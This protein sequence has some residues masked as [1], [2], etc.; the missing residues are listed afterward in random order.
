MTM[1]IKLSAETLETLNYF[2]RIGQMVKIK[3][4]ADWLCIASGDTVAVADI[5]ETF[6]RDVNI[7]DLNEIMSIFNVVKEPTLDLTEDNIIYIKTSDLSLRYI[8]G[9]GSNIKTLAKKPTL[10]TL[11]SI[12]VELELSIE[13]IKKMNSLINTLKLPY[14]GF[15]GEEGKLYFKGFN[16]NA[17]SDNN[18]MN[19]CKILLGDNNTEFE[20]FAFVYTRDVLTYLTEDCK[21]YLSKHFI[22][23]FDFENRQVFS[24]GD[25]VLSSF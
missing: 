1:E 14:V 9:E 8:E 22:G 21:V 17:D 18:E 23:M 13:N 7:Y 25:K 6:P 2:Q 5:T 10:E 4:D 20:N 12:D 16:K 19:S 3:K 15:V 24:T 11:P